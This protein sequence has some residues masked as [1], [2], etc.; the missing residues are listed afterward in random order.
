MT[1]GHGW[2]PAGVPDTA[3]PP[4]QSNSAVAEKCGLSATMV[5]RLRNGHRVPSFDTMRKVQRAFQIDPHDMD[6]WFLLVMEEGAGG[7]KRFLA[8][9]WG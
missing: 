8:S 6:R 7:S 3:P 5:S 9:L 4:R 1:E 2:Y